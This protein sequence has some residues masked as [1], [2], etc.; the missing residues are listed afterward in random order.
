MIRV[1]DHWKSLGVIVLM[2]ALATPSARADGG[3]I[4]LDQRC[5]GYRIVAFTQPTPLRVGAVDLSVLVQDAETRK[6]LPDANV[7]LMVSRRG[8]GFHMQHNATQAAATYRLLRAARFELPQ[9]GSYNTRVVVAGQHGT[10]MA[11]FDLIVAP[12]LPRWLTMW[13]WLFWPVV[14]I[15]LYAW[16]T[17]AHARRRNQACGAA[18]GRKLGSD[19]RRHR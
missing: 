5:G 2:L 3:A 8:G 7:S 17:V 12:A 11:E 6:A 1:A 13:P 4:R 9:P 10:A 18:A 16:Q 14:P 19:Q 15:A